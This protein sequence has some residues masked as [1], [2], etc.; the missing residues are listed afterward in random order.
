MPLTMTRIRFTMRRLMAVVALSAVA[1][2]VGMHWSEW[3]EAVQYWWENRA[4]LRQLDRKVT[5]HYPQGV[6]FSQLCGDIKKQTSAVGSPGGLTI[7]IDP[8]GEGVDESGLTTT[9][10]LKIDV[11]DIPLRDAL[12][13]ILKPIKLRLYVMGGMASVSGEDEMDDKY[14]Q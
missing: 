12:R 10:V 14:K 7:Y 9:A 5:F 3:S 4:I 6:S 2:W 1:V 8:E 11:Q 13:S